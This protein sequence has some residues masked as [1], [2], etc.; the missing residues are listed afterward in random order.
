M[1]KYLKLVNESTEDNQSESDGSDS[2]P[3]EGELQGSD[4]DEL[5]E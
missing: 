5:F 1:R 3:S 2:N 4:K